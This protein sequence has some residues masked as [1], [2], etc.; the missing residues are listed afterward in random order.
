[1]RVVLLLIATA[2]VLMTDPVQGQPALDLEF[3]IPQDIAVTGA[4]PDLPPDHARFLGAWGPGAW[5]GK[6]GHVLVVMEVNG[7][8]EAR[9]LYATAAWPDWQVQRGSWL[10]KGQI[11]DGRL[12]VKLLHGSAEYRIGPDGVMR[13]VHE[14]QTGRATIEL[15]RGDLA[16]LQAKTAAAAPRLSLPYDKMRIPFPDD[17]GRSFETHLYRPAGKPPFRLAIFHH[18]S[19]DG[20]D[21]RWIVPPEALIEYLNARGYLVA[22]PYRRGRGPSDG[23]HF[24]TSEH[25]FDFGRGLDE[26]IGDVDRITEKLLERDDVRPGRA[27][28]LGQSRGGILAIAYAARRPEKISGVVNFVGGWVG[29][30]RQ[31]DFNTRTFAHAGQTLPRP[32]LW[33]YG[34]RDPYYPLSHSRQNFAAFRDAGGRGDLHEFPDV[35]PDGHRVIRYPSLWRAPLADFLDALPD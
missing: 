20:I 1:M 19:A 3:V 10:L 27:L 16:I 9:L 7:A 2:M 11:A 22:A 33:L 6:L 30:G 26:A 28:L 5:G 17:S 4:N 15:R 31:A 8:G 32:T 29:F 14:S 34:D 18:G 24:Q 35:M 12:K 21:P 25:S 23:N 13:G